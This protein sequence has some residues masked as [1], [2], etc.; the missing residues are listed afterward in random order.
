MLRPHLLQYTELYFVMLKIDEL[1]TNIGVVTET[2]SDFQHLDFDSMNPH[3]NQNQIGYV[4]SSGVYKD[5]ELS[6]KIFYESD[7]KNQGFLRISVELIFR[8]NDA[9]TDSRRLRLISNEEAD[10]WRISY[11]DIASSHEPDPGSKKGDKVASRFLIKVVEDSR[12]VDHRDLSS[13]I[14]QICEEF[15]GQ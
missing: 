12:D 2:V 4:H 15:L 13:F 11:N 14:Q 7:G 3:G 1:I 8:D 5:I 10:A 9:R 6:W